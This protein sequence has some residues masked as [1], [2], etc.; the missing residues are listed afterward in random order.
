MERIAELYYINNNSTAKALLDNWVEWVISE[1]Q[2]YDDGTFEIP[3]TLSWSGQPETWDSENPQI[4]NDL[5]VTVEDYGVDLGVAACLAKALTYYAAG[6]REYDVL[7]VEARDL[8]KE[9][10]DRMWNNYYEADGEGLA[11]TETRSDYSRFFEQEVYIPDG[12]SGKMGNGDTIEPGV[13]FIDI[14]S[15]YLDDPMYADLKEAYDNGTDFATKYHR[16]WA[17]V[18]IALANAEYGRLFADE[19]SL[20]TVLVTG[21][22][23]SADSVIFEEGDTSILTASVSPFNAT[24]DSVIWSSSDSLVA[25]VDNGTISAFS[26][27]SAIIT[28]TTVDG[29]YSDTAI[30]EVNEQSPVNEYALTIT[31]VGM[32]EVVSDPDDG[33]YEEGTT[34]SL[35]AVADE[36]YVFDSW[37]G[38]VSGNET[39]LSLVMTSDISV[40]AVFVEAGD[41]CDDPEE[42]TVPFSF[43]GVGEYCWVTSESFSYINSWNLDQLE[44]NGV[45]YTNI[46]SNSLPES[47]DGMYYISYTGSYDW[48]H[49]EISSTKSTGIDI[50][51]D[52]TDEEVSGVTV[53]PNPFVNEITMQIVSP[54]E[55]FS[56]QVIDESGHVIEFYNS[57]LILSTMTFGQGWTSGMYF[58]RV[59]KDGRSELVKVTKQ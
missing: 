17:Q 35:T 29:G 54:D 2:L 34:V 32:G 56:I 27:G 9:L 21:V 44:I 1:T 12:W 50:V 45:D 23:L 16:F 40:T 28:V 47:E 58:I 36:N 11:V 38:D 18:D 10:L 39:T 5:H 43:D 24:N 15:G 20:D 48:S 14:R 13:K 51:A 8:A 41:F 26:Q 33:I 59:V 25:S 37:T 31:I 53:W 4:N 52:G 19:L 7:D 22:T 3:T 30:V 55:V 6:T 49:F 57:S 42:I 46:W